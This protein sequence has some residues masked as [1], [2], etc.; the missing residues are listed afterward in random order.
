MTSSHNK[1]VLLF[2]GVCNLCNRWVNVVIDRDPEAAIRFA[3]LQSNTARK[4]LKK[5]QMDSD[6]LET[7]VFLEGDQVYLR[8]DAVLRIARYLTFPARLIRVFRVIPKFLRDGVYNFV[9]NKRYDMFG[10]RDE[11]RIPEPGIKDRFLEMDE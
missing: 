6:S 1:P 9:A 5:H 10:K 3:P 7:V 8:S 2:D 4:L 11:C